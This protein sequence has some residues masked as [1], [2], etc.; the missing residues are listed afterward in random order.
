MLLLHGKDSFD[1]ASR[2][3]VLV[4]QV[5]DDAAVAVDGDAFRYQILFDHVGKRIPFD[6][7]RMAATRKPC[8]RKI[9]RSAELHDTLRDLVRVSLLFVRMVEELLGHALRMDAARHE[10]VA[11]VAQ[12]AHELGGERIVQ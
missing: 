9:G 4:A 12:Y 7:L 3:R 11:P 5:L 2:S 1:H 10:V 8:G 6:V